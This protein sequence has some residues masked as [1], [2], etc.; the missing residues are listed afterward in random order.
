MLMTFGL[1]RGEILELYLSDVKV[2]GRKPSLTIE[3]RPGDVF[4]RAN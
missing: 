4:D 1:R 3:R 2:Q